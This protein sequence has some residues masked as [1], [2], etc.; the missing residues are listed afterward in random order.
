[1]SEYSWQDMISLS[2]TILDRTNKQTS[3]LLACS[4]P[5]YLLIKEI[6]RIATKIGS[7]YVMKTTPSKVDSIE[8]NTS[9]W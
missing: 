2:L 4:W 3:G 9:E 1:M 8:G 7:N 5:V 6:H